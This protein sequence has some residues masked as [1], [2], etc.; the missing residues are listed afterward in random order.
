MHR[1]AIQRQADR[2]RI[3]V[4]A[5]V[6]MEEADDYET[7]PPSRVDSFFFD[8]LAHASNRDPELNSA[9]KEF[10]QFSSR[11]TR[12]D[13]TQLMPN[14]EMP[15]ASMQSPH[16]NCAKGYAAMYSKLIPLKE[17]MKG[18]ALRFSSRFES[19]VSVTEIPEGAL[20]EGMKE[21]HM[22]ACMTSVM[23]RIAST[24]LESIERI[25]KHVEHIFGLPDGCGG[26]K[27]SHS[28]EACLYG[29]GNFA[30]IYKKK[31]VAATEKDRYFIVVHSDSG[32]V[33]SALC[34]WACQ[35]P[36]MTLGEFAGSPHMTRVKEYSHRNNAR[37]VARI[38]NALGVDRSAVKIK[39]D[40][41]ARV[42]R[43]MDESFPDKAGGF[44]TK[45]VYNTFYDP[46]PDGHS[47]VYYNACTKL[48]SGKYQWV[49][50]MLGLKKGIALYGV[51]PGKDYRLASMDMIRE[52]NQIVTTSHDNHFS[53][54]PVSVGSVRSAAEAGK[55]GRDALTKM[56]QQYMWIDKDAEGAPEN[57]RMTHYRVPDDEHMR[58]NRF[59]LGK[60]HVAERDFAL[61]PVAV[62][63]PP[64]RQ[65]DSD[66]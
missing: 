26:S 43:D 36:N 47:L 12:D 6:I 1:D 52:G 46:N 39:E 23:P 59:M 25:E 56:K 60:E 3:S 61:S 22:R 28:W 20:P 16:S 4:H 54:W 14:F 51:Q 44:L 34:A 48:G 41:Q 64:A 8:P 57:Y 15:R 24:A 9:E 50:Q 33:G 19:I 5:T 7:A 18:E 38:M 45:I 13:H 62:V 53:A 66:S 2:A 27:D 49:P 11:V 10:V 55:I 31:G 42:N 65:P 35:N 30:G 40:H 29:S 37:I 32:P 63:L 21:E 58:F 17:F